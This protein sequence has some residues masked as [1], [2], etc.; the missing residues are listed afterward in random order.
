[1]YIL[2]NVYVALELCCLVISKEVSF[3]RNNL[4]PSRLAE[5]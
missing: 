3:K 2:I 5:A 1:M 4:K